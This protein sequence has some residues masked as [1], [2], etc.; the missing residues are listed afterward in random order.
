M[1]PSSVLIAP[2]RRWCDRPKR[3]EHTLLAIF[4]PRKV[5]HNPDAPYFLLHRDLEENSAVTLWRRS[6]RNERHTPVERHNP[7]GVLCV[8]PMYNVLTWLS[9]D[10]FESIST[11]TDGYI[12]M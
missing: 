4:L 6:I 5:G 11:P 1:K 10:V 3:P 7:V 8:T 9:T 12:Q 2:R